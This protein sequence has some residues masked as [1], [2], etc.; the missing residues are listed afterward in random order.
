MF[1]ASL[2]LNLWGGC[3]VSIVVGEALPDISFI[4]DGAVDSFIIAISGSWPPT[5]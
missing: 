2:R 1:M 4:I 3:S 5:G